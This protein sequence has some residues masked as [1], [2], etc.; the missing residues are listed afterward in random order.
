M[1]KPPLVIMTP[2][3]GAVCPA[4]IRSGCVT[5]RSDA[6]EIRPDTSKTHTRGYDCTTQSRKVPAP[7][8]AKE[9]TL[10]TLKSFCVVCVG[11]A[12]AVATVGT[13]VKVA[14]GVAVAGT[15]VHVAVGAGVKV[16]V[17]V[18]VGVPVGVQVGVH[19]GVGVCVDVGVDVTGTCVGVGVDPPAPASEVKENI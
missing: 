14:V 10:S 15:G 6:N 16:D 3:D 17:A 5:K 13:A 1:L 18:H 8:S 11:T 19:V 2:G 12:V 4:T 7:L 9:V